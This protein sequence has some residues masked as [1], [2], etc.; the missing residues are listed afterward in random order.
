MTGHEA[1][2]ALSTIRTLMERST[3]YRNL[4]ADAG[5]AAGTFTLLGVWL[6]WRF[7][8]PFIPTWIGVLV[9]ALLASLAFTA[10]MAHANREPVW[11]RQARTVC[12]ALTPAFLAGLVMTAVMHRLGREEE[13]PGT[14]MLLWG[15]GA[16]AMSF[17]TPRV[18]TLLGASFMLAGTFT[19]L[20]GPFND[21]LSMAATF[22]GIHL[23]Y[24]L[25]LF[26][27]P[28]LQN[29]PAWSL[30]KG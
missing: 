15:V 6:R 4:S 20:A 7:D 2:E 24:G 14:W 17:F 1:E 28:R 10:V 27:A 26:L 8:T 25:V 16:L 12:L 29:T 3:R 19:L 13:L 18:I 30:L 9:A 22:G 21:A 5:I 23:L 11:S